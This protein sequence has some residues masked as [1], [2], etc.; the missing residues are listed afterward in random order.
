MHV[1]GCGR[2]T[3]HGGQKKEKKNPKFVSVK[4]ER[5]NFITIY[6]YIYFIVVI[7][8]TSNRLKIN[9]NA[10]RKNARMGGR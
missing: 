9:K 4:A 10:L 1:I 7:Y 2:T 5:K 3:P 6:V 8:N